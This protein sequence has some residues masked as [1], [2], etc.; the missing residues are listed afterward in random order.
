MRSHSISVDLSNKQIL[1]VGKTESLQESD[2]YAPANRAHIQW[3]RQAEVFK[4]KVRGAPVCLAVCA[5]VP[6]GICLP[7]PACVC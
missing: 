7:V 5:F 3:E 6:I 2:P 4:G 1:Q